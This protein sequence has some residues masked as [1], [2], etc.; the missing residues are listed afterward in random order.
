MT[1]TMMIRMTVIENVEKALVISVSL[2]RIV[3]M[4]N[5]TAKFW[6]KLRSQKKKKYS[7]TNVF[8]VFAD[9]YTSY[10]KRK[11]N[12]YVCVEVIFV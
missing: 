11:K 10:K 2:G 3:V 7:L 6:Q 8:P 1:T 4:T 9:V 12:C 5:V